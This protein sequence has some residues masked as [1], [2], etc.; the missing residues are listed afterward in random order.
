VALAEI[1]KELLG[2]DS[3]GR[4]DNFFDLGGHSLL[5]MRL[6]YQVEARLGAQLSA[7]DV[8]LNT[9]DQLA[10]RCDRATSG[11]GHAT[12]PQRPGLFRRVAAAIR[13]HR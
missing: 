6:I 11:N 1:W 4:S 9:L 12:P 13:G 5:S 2:I 7:R 8:V 10:A 3:V